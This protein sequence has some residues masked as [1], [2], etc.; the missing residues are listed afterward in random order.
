[1][2]LID[3]TGHLNNHDDYV[4][5]INRINDKCD[6]IEIVILDKKESNKLV[7]KFSEFIIEKKKVKKWWGTELLCK[8]PCNSLYKIKYNKH[9]YLYLLQ[10]ETF[11]KYFEFGTSEKSLKIGDYSEI[12]DFG[13]DDIAFYDSEGNTLL[14]TTTHEGYI[15]INEKL[16]K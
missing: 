13:I 9:I 1:M 8:R 4:K 16:I 7:D 3:Y 11:C 2:G 6:Y 5:I 12:T 15:M 14:N 10:F